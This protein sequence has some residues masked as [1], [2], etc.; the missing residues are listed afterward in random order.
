[1]VSKYDDESFVRDLQAREEDI[2][3]AQDFPPSPSRVPG[4][5]SYDV[6]EDEPVSTPRGKNITD[7]VREALA[8]QRDERSSDD[9]DSEDSGTGTGSASAA[10]GEDD[11]AI[12]SFSKGGVAKQTQRAL[13]SSRKK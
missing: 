1:M 3:D 10:G 8:Q 9:A 5:V 2:E 7:E 12:G 6:D 13:K 4:R 11:E